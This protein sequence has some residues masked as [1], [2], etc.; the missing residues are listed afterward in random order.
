[1]LIRSTPEGARDYLVPSR[2]NPG[3][4]FALPQS[5]QLFKQ[6]LMVSGFDRYYQI[7]RCFR[8]EDLRADRQPEFTQ[9]DMEMSF[10]SQEEILALNEGLV[11]ELFSQI[12][13]MEIPRP[14][15][16]LSYR[17]A[18]ARYG[19]DK[20]DTRFGMELVDTSDLFTGSGF[21]VFAGVLAAGGKV[22]C[23]PVPGGDGTIT[24]TRIKPGGDLFEFVAQF[25]AKGLAFMRIREGNAI[26]TIG[27]LKDTLTPELS[28]ELLRRTD[29]EPGHLLLF[30]AAEEAV[31]QNYLGRLRLRLGEE[32]GFIDPDRI[33]LLWVTDFP[34]FEYDAEHKRLEPLHHPFTRPHPADLE[35][36]TTAR[37]LAYD[38]VWNGVE[39]GG[40][41]LRIYERA[42]QEKVFAAIG[43]GDEEAKQKFGF[44][45]EAFEYG[46]P[47][48]GGIAYGFDRLTML[49]AG[50]DNLR[51]VIAFP[52]T[53][54]AQDPM[55]GAPSPVAR[56]QL[57]ELHVRSTLPPG[58]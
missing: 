48:H 35:D 30:G 57:D 47:P 41:S 16:R 36:L 54:R 38:L 9:L 29:A 21:K 22:V 52:K 44:L 20:P 10:L 33:D 8:D 49:F 51:E 42:L 5:P 18:M 46:T 19:S 24:N 28:A 43:L 11:A 40:G 37:A 32:L 23:L 31:V 7:A 25:G 56:K 15:P 50:E 2:V 6:L 53:Q 3:E 4:W 39:V 27:A 45:L 17:E 55:S 58:P 1:M 14:V 34:M 12:K 26:D 13:G